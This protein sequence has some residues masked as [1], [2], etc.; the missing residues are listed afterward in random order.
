MLQLMRLILISLGVFLAVTGQQIAFGQSDAPQIRFKNKLRG[1]IDLYLRSESKRDFTLVGSRIAVGSERDVSLVSDDRFEI[2]AVYRSTRA[3]ENWGPVYIKQ[4]ARE[5]PGLV[6]SLASISEMKTRQY[7]ET[8]MVPRT[9]SR[10]CP[11]C[12]GY[13]DV[14]VNVP[15]QRVRVQNLEVSRPILQYEDSNGNYLPLDND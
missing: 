3:R 8:V 4:K 7:T 6:V 9:E 2:V 10:W 5:N 14:T 13:H 15:E 1:E 12:G 11:N